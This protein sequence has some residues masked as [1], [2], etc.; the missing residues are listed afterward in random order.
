M[1]RS[2]DGK[3]ISSHRDGNGLR[4][5]IRRPWFSSGNDEKLAV[6][7]LTATAPNANPKIDAMTTR[8]GADPVFRLGDVPAN[9]GPGNFVGGGNAV[10]SLGAPDIANATATV[11]PYAV[12]FDSDRQMWYADITI[13]AGFAYTPFVRLALARYQQYAL[14]GLNLSGVVVAD[15]MQIQMD[16]SASIVFDDSGTRVTAALIGVA[17]ESAAGANQIYGTIQEKVGPDDDTGWRTVTVGGK[18]LSRKIPIRPPGN[19][20][21]T[22][23]PN[24]RITNPGGLVRPPVRIPPPG[25]GGGGG[26]EEPLGEDHLEAEGQGTLRQGTLQNPP[27]RPGVLNPAIKPQIRDLIAQ[28]PGEGVFVLPKPRNQGTYRLVI[29]EYEVFDTDSGEM[30][31]PD[32][33]EP[34]PSTPQNK[35]V[36]PA[37]AIINAQREVGARLVYMDVIPLS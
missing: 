28:Q 24:E 29:R 6:V 23:L 32:V 12:H 4:V 8:A 17:G 21:I 15:I 20:G 1:T 36:S 11:V 30:D 19:L 14:P 25:G 18:E 35:S 10:G 2:T 3:Q 33:P 31:M 34:T 13:N 9:F 37:A 5:Y 27:I 7:F 26:G 16:R 22:T